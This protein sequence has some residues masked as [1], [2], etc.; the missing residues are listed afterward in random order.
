MLDLLTI[1]FGSFCIGFGIAYILA[2]FLAALPDKRRQKPMII[3]GI[4]LMIFGIIAF[5]SIK[6][7][8]VS[9][10]YG[11]DRN[12][13]GHDRIFVDPRIRKPDPHPDQVRLDTGNYMLFSA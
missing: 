2:G 7:L 10:A 11:P 6:A 4:I 1:L 5:L 8:P 13:E 3:S 12:G 9:P